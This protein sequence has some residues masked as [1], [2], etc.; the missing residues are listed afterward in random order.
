M[1]LLKVVNDLF[2]S[3]DMNIPSVAILLGLSAACNT[4]DHLKLLEI[5]HKEIG[6]TC[7]ALGGLNPF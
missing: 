2:Q 7:V 6:V 5:L 4:V 1:L 3:F